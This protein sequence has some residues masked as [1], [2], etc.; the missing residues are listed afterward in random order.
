MNLKGRQDRQAPDPKAV[1]SVIKE[2][3]DKTYGVPVEE[4][5]PSPLTRTTISIPEDLL[6]QVEDLAHENKRAR[7]APKSVSGVIVDALRLYLLRESD[8][9]EG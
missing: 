9:S 3:A 1:E 5:K 2:L 7:A 4:P 6:I 8:D